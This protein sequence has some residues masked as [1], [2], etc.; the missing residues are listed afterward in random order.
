MITYTSEAYNWKA[1]QAWFFVRIP[2]KLPPENGLGWRGLIIVIMAL[3][4][5]FI[6]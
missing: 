4:S 2:I 6:G 3:E 5:E 1:I